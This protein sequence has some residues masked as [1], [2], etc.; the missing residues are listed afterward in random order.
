MRQTKRVWLQRPVSPLKNPGCVPLARAALCHA[1]RHE[2][3]PAPIPLTPDA[4]AGA[5]ANVTALVRACAAAAVVAT[6]EYDLRAEDV[7]A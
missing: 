4:G 3:R 6:D 7:A 2:P 5:R 1:A